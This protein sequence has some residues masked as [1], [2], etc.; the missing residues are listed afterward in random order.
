M[1]IN[2][3]RLLRRRILAGVFVGGMVMSEASAQVGEEL[4]VPSPP[5]EEDP[6]VALPR[7]QDRP[8]REEPFIALPADRNDQDPLVDGGLNDA[9]R[10]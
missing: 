3:G 7:S 9:G 6:F 1:A 4:G 10:A 2:R 8:D 5:P